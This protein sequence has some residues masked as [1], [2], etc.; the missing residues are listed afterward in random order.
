MAFDLGSFLLGWGAGLIS[1]PVVRRMR[2]LVVELAAAMGQLT[3]TASVGAAQQGER[4]QDLFSEAKMAFQSSRVGQAARRS[5]SAETTYVPV[6]DEPAPERPR[7]RGR[8]RTTTSRR[9]KRSA[10]SAATA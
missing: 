3:E 6:T 9:S 4:L 5:A 1:G 7:R 2:P 10:T 8:R